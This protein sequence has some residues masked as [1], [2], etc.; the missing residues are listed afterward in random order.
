MLCIACRQ[1]IYR[2]PELHQPCSVLVR[3]M[4]EVLNGLQKTLV[5]RRKKHGAHHDH[6]MECMFSLAAELAIRQRCTKSALAKLVT[7]D[8]VFLL[9]FL[10]MI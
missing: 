5:D 1:T 3:H 8:G 6:T 10:V 2:R 4:C 7:C 9:G